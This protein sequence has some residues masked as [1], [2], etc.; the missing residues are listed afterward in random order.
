MWDE[1]N[2]VYQ[3]D[4]DEMFL[5]LVSQE[6]K[7]FFL[8]FIKQNP[9]NP[10]DDRLYL[11]YRALESIIITFMTEGSQS[12]VKKLRFENFLTFAIFL[13]I[14]FALIRNFGSKP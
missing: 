6:V 12:L 7:D 13:M 10:D 8:V 4:F 1:T 14:S 9:E 2:F 5:N 3:E 11:L